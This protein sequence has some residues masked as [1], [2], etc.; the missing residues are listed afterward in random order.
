MITI[1]V[2]NTTCKITGNVDAKVLAEISKECSYVHSGYMYMATQSKYNRSWDG[3]VRLYKNSTFPIGLLSRVKGILRKNKVSFGVEDMRPPV[4]Y[5]EP[6]LIDKDCFFKPRDYQCKAL[7]SCIKN[8]SG[9]VK[10]ATGGGKTGVIAMLS[11]HYNVKTIIYV[12]GVELLYQ[13]KDTLNT[14]YPDLEVGI[15]G[16]GKCDVKNINIATIWSAAAAFNK[17][18]KVYDSD[19]TYDKKAN[20]SINK[21]AV[22]NA[23]RSAD[24]FILDECQYAGAN[25]VQFLHKESISARHR[26]LF[27]ASPWRDSGDDILIEAVGG[28]KIYDLKASSLIKDGWLVMPEIH[29]LSVPPMRGVGSNYQDVYKRYIV[30]NETRNEMICNS[31]QKL[32]SAGKNVLIL[33]TRINHGNI[34]VKALREKGLDCEFLDGNKNSNERLETIGRM[35][36]GELNLLVASKIFDQ[37][38]DIPEL[39]ALILAGSGKS[40]GRALQRIGR[41]I[42]KSKGKKR[43]IV[44]EFDDNA[45]YLKNHSEA[46]FNVYKSEPMFKIKRTGKDR[47]SEYKKRPPVKWA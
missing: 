9:V 6:L 47:S 11:G 46:R 43:A 30:E 42:R 7:D 37:G 19:V 10:M 41:V 5:G 31:A 24:M 15:I 16:D 44:V 34:L 23:V 12:I 40:S 1:K 21:E 29:F 32:M 3:I 39:N 8:S 2:T 13:M 26:F 14:L 45:K 25:T 36:K 35:K 4:S 22:R 18:I 20:S 33:V 17:K 38:V 27:S 28:K